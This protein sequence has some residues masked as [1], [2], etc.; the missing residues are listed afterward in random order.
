M[1]S[2]PKTP[3]EQAEDPI[4]ITFTPGALTA[5]KEFIEAEGS[6][7]HG[8]RVAVVGGGCNGFQYDL[9]LEENKREPDLELKISGIRVFIDSMSLE[10]LRGTEIDFVKNLSGSGF[11]FKNPNSTQSCSCGQSFST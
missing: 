4:P 5:I 3:N 11:I 6:P 9:A 1:T 7:D 8:L 2:S 10:Y